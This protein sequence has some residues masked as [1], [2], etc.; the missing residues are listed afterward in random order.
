MLRK[1]TSHN[2]FFVEVIKKRQMQFLAKGHHET[3]FVVGKESINKADVSCYFLAFWTMFSVISSLSRI[4]GF[5]FLCHFEWRRS[6]NREI[7][8][9]ARLLIKKVWDLLTS[10]RFAQDDIVIVIS[11]SSRNPQYFLLNK[12]KIN[13]YYTAS[14]VW[15]VSTALHYAQHDMNYEM[16]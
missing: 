3:T 2:T 6:R 9:F 7:S 13:H 16:T 11:S 8:D 12:H 10:L 4:F 1:N 14:V 5:G 15:D